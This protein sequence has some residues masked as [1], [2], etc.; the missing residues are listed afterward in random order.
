MSLQQID[1]QHIEH[2]KNCNHF[3]ELL[4]HLNSNEKNYS[5][6]KSLC[7]DYLHIDF[8]INLIL[9]LFL[10]NDVERCPQPDD[11]DKL[12]D[13]VQSLF[14]LIVDG[15]VED[16]LTDRIRLQFNVHHVL[17]QVKLCLADVIQNGYE[18]NTRISHQKINI[19]FDYLYSIYTNIFEVQD[20]N[21]TESY[22]G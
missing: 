10:N 4:I 22:E 1:D 21:E 16:V 12:I 14:Q 7:L 18:K 2:L 8:F 6:F 13:W 19:L 17:E 11:D 5:L 20:E 9:L 15:N 3:K